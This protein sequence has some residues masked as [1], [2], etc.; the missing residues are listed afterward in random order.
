MTWLYSPDY[1]D[2]A[3]LAPSFVDRTRTEFQ[4][5]C[6]IVLQTEGDPAYRAAFVVSTTY[7]RLAITRPCCPTVRA[8]A[9]PAWSCHSKRRPKRGCSP[10]GLPAG[11]PRPSP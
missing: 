6:R 1:P 2:D 5:G 7:N 3:P 10:P 11:R 8:A 4:R 9:H